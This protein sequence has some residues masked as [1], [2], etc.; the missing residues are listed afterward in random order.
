VPLRR[1]RGI[2]KQTI[3]AARRPRGAN[4]TAIN[5]RAFDSR[6]EYTIEARITRPQRPKASVGIKNHMSF[7]TGIRNPYSPFSDTKAILAGRA[8][9]CDNFR[10]EERWRWMRQIF[11]GLR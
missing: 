1:R 2:E 6:E 10:R 4:G 11:A 3:L 7:L 5:S 8:C 9:E